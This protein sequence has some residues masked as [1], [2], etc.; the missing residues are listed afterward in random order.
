MMTANQLSVNRA[1]RVN[2]L[3]EFSTAVMPVAVGG[4]GLLIVFLNREGINAGRSATIA[5]MNLFLDDLFFILSCLTVFLLVSPGAL[6]N[7]TSV[8]ASTAEVVFWIVFPLLCVW[9]GI[10]YIGLFRCPNRIAWFF[11]YV[12]RLKIL[13][14][15]ES[16]MATFTG[17]MTDASKDIGKRSVG[18]WLK[19]F[20]ATALTWSSRFLVVNAL[21]MAFTTAGNPLII[22]GRQIMLW[23]IMVISPTP[24]GSGLSEIAFKEIY[25]DLALDAGSILLIICIWRLITYY[26]YLFAGIILIPNWIK[27]S[28]RKKNHTELHRFPSV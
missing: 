15:W 11:R 18:F 22:F 14:R 7:H 6:F 27:K 8:I 26:T 16:Q 12:F 1:L 19:S 17:N 9:T 25:N 10:L 28:F 24:G 5:M 13:H 23:L 21:F 4:G 2:I 20:L 3:R